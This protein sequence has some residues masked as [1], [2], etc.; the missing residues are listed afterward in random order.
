MG[1]PNTI[2][3]NIFE[4]SVMGRRPGTANEKSFGL[5]LSTSKQIVE[6]HVGRIGFENNKP[7]GS[8]F[9]VALTLTA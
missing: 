7:T 9:F 5:G 6:E 2:S 1:I 4:N 3:Q 8:T